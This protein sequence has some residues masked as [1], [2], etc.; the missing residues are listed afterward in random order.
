MVRIR[1]VLPYDLLATVP[2]SSAALAAS[3]AAAGLDAT[4]PSCPGWTVEKLVRHTGS[5]LRLVAKVVETGG[6]VDGRTLP[7]PPAGPL[8]LQWFQEMEGIT[9]GAL[10][11]KDP[12]DELWNW[13]DQPPVVSFWQRRMAHEVAMHAAD[14]ALA[15]GDKPEIGPQLA[16]DGIDE[17]LGVLLLAKVGAG[18]T[19][20]SDV[21]SLHVHCTDTEGEWLVAPEGARVEVSR[22]HA[23]GDAALRGPASDL[24]LR[25]CKRGAGGE[26]VGDPSVLATLT[27]RFTF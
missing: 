20:L 25:L 7:R 23:K 16:A 19:D 21:G 3:A 27:E 15:A 5:V 26:V 11:A 1:A 9:V 2:T 13:A 18:G 24:L 4:V 10:S 6:P 12:G 17:L 22:V 14:A 8:V